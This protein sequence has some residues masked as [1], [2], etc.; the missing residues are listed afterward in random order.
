MQRLQLLIVHNFL[1]HLNISKACRLIKLNQI[2][3]YHQMAVASIFPTDGMMGPS[4]PIDRITAGSSM[5]APGGPTPGEQVI[6]EEARS[7]YFQQL[8]NQLRGAGSKVAN[9]AD[10]RGGR[11]AA[12]VAAPT[13][14]GLGSLAQGQIAQGVGEIGGGVVG[15]GLVGGLANAA[16]AALPG[17]KGKLAA[18]GIRGV[19]GLVGGAV[20]GGVAG[21]AAQAAGNVVS[22]VTGQQR[23]EGKSP[24]LTGGTGVGDLSSGKL[25]E[26][27]ELMRRTGRVGVEQQVALMNQVANPYLD[28]QLQRQMQLNQQLGQLTGALNRQQYAFQLA[29]GAQEQAGANLRTMITSNPY[30]G[31]TFRA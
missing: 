3:K 13:A 25:A 24:S 29:G 4:T 19:G 10:T 12:G 1:L 18:A 28:R 7:K 5:F 22:A 26:I 14:Y 15:A 31:S 2:G 23:E 17:A 11:I 16:Q 20:G 6:S 21:Q 9:A 8:M 27:E 30:A